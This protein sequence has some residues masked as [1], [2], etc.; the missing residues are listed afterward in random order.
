[1]SR[2]RRRGRDV[3]GVLLLDK[4]GALP[5]TTCCRKLSVFITPTVRATP[6]RSIRW[7]PACCRSVWE[8]RQNFPSTCSTP[9]SVTALSLSW[10]SARIP[11]T[12]MAVVE[13]RPVT[14]SAEQL[15]AALESFRGET[16]QVPSMYSA[17]KYQGKNS[18]NTRGALTSRVKPVRLPCMSCSLFATK[19]MSW[20]W[21]CTARKGLIF[22]PSLMT[23]V[24][25]WAAARM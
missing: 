9:I 16:M 17:L 15:D 19:A 22:A 11:P 6:A 12:R 1:M 3:H 13:E 25:S 20:S 18:T 7:Q 5:A 24:K 21:K 8:R 10:A 4:P 23:S 2:P 14:F